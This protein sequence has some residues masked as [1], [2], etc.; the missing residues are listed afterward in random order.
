M[1]VKRQEAQDT[2]DMQLSDD[3]RWRRRV[4]LAVM[5]VLV[6]LVT[7]LAFSTLDASAFEDRKS[8][9]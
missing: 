3:V 7:L 9:V 8:V 2:A 1:M 6:A 4:M 5:A